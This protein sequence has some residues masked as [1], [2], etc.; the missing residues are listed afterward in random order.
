MKKASDKTDQRKQRILEALGRRLEKDPYTQITVQDI[1]EEAGYSKGG[2]LYYYPTKEAVY[3]DYMERFF[4][5]IERD[6][7]SV[8]SDNLQSIE[9]AGISALYGVEKFLL[10]AKTTRILINLLMYGFEDER[11]MEPIRDFSRKLL[12]HYRSIIE[13]ARA[14]LPFRRKS[15]F[16]PVFI[17]RIV[18][19][20]LLSAGLFESVDPIAIDPYVLVR[21]TNSLFKG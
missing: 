15:E 17:A 3:L 14:E 4:S 8:I 13:S 20:V 18:Q 21:Y 1:A 7:L 12:N 10:D 11:I 5:E 2:L 19:I 9:K 16:D 6:H